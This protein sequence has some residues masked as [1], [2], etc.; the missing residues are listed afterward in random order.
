MTEYQK[1]DRVTVAEFT[2]TVSGRTDPGDTGVLVH[3]G[4]GD[5]FCAF[6][7]RENVTPAEPEYEV[8]VAY[9]DADGDVFVRT[10]DADRPWVDPSDRTSASDGMRQTFRDD[11]PTRPLQRLVDVEAAK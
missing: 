7:S 11:F 2:A 5:Q 8:G 9:E 6:V 3:Y 4:D 10:A 1:G